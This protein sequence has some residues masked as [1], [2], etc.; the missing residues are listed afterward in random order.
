[1]FHAPG[2]LDS[3]DS[4]VEGFVIHLESSLIEVLE[5]D[6]LVTI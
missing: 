1:L 6:N 4:R 3:Q 2:L 5:K